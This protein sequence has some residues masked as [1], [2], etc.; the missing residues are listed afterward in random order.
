MQYVGAMFR[1]PPTGP[2]DM[3]VTIRDEMGDVMQTHLDK[4]D[5]SRQSGQVVDATVLP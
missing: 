4:V 1:V 5:I 2:H 3:S